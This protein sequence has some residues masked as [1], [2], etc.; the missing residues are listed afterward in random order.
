MENESGKN[1]IIRKIWKC[2]YIGEF[3]TNTDKNENTMER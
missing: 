2:F 3:K 1:E